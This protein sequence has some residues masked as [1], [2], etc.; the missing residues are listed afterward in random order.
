MQ[1]RTEVW[2]FDSRVVLKRIFRDLD[3]VYAKLQ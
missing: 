3:E 2:M 1:E